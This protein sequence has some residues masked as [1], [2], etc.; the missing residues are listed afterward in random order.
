[1]PKKTKKQ[2]IAAQSRHIITIKDT[3]RSE[4]ETSNNPPVSLSQEKNHDVVKLSAPKNIPSLKEDQTIKNYFIAD[5]KKSFIFISIIIA[6][7]FLI[8]YASMNLEF[9]KLLKF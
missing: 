6:L 7:E 4:S 5:A 2:K 9:L 3:V 1:M 8:Y